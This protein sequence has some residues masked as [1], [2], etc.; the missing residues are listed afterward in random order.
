MSG[1]VGTASG[2]RSPWLGRDRWRRLFRDA[3]IVPLIGLLL[4]IVL[5]LEIVRPG[6]VN[7][8]WAAVTIRAAVPL[9]ILAACQTLTMLTG[10]ID[11]SVGMVASAAAYIMATQSAQ[12]GPGQAI[13]LGF[14]AAALAGL[15]NGIGVGVFRVHP[16]IM[17]LG[18]SL[19]VLGLLTVYQL[20]AVTAGV[21]VPE[22]IGSLGADLSFGFVPNSLLVFV[23]IM[24]ILLFGLRRT[25]FG[26][27]LYAIGDNPVASRLAGVRA[28]QVLVALYILSALLAAVA[29]ILF[30][31]LSKTASLSQM[32]RSV[33]PSVAAAVI[34]GTSIMGGRGGYAGTIV[35]A[36]ILTV[37]T[38]LLNV[39]QMP[40]GVRQIL[41]GAIIVTVAAAYTRVT[42]ES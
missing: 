18:M 36:V 25:G 15:A 17:T 4:L 34:G 32:E 6:I 38:V 19:I 28:W 40:E 16:L 26:R 30:A 22:A 13:A 12:L 37:L 1:A 20:T 31:G 5:L 27:L 14:L 39:L 9:A 3:P 7:L 23:P 35:G 42:G 33:L 11:L 8:N 21:R 29:G 2:T 41:F 24:V 10:G